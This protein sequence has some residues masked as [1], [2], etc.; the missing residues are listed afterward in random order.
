VLSGHP[1]YGPPTLEFVPYLYT[2]LHAW[3]CAAIVRVAG[4]EL[5]PL[6]AVSLAASLVS[7]AFIHR[8]A[9]RR[10]GSSL[11]GLLALG[12]F[13]ATYRAAGAWLDLAR[14]DA[15]FLALLLA[16]LDAL[17]SG[18]ERARTWAAPAWLFL[19]FLTKQ[20]A[21][22]LIVALALADLRR[23]VAARGRFAAVALGAPALAVALGQWL[24]HGWFAW[25]VFG[26]P[27]RHAPAISRVLGFWTNDLLLA[28]PVVLA[29]GALAW[30]E[31]AREPAAASR[32]VRDGFA[33]AGLI[34]TSYLSGLHSGGYD[35]VLLP[36]YA[37]LAIAFGAGV[38]FALRALPPARPAQAIVLLAVLAQF[39]RLAYAPQA[40]I[41]PA[42]GRAEGER[43][44]RRAGAIDGPLWWSDHPGYLVALGRPP[45][46]QDNALRDVLRADRGGRWSVALRESLR[47]AVAER[48]YAA[49]VTD[50]ADFPLRPEG[51]EERYALADSALT[52]AAFRPVTGWDRRP[53]YLWVR[54]AP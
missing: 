35:N 10:A 2:P 18:D 42:G 28:L 22:V 7:L 3:A 53:T 43:L 39:A 38:G 13:A 41:P 34:A 4:P 31:T 12:L 30:R 15:L 52:G 33:L 40:Q 45:Q 9:R 48:R 5:P 16:G 46:A 14:V 21:L 36:A 19:A 32:R 8:L 50:F 11:A 37:G 6:R 29:L 20:S 54:R 25:Y 51:F 24:T 27:A 47:V 44:L 26:L 49:F 17:D 1:L 23:P